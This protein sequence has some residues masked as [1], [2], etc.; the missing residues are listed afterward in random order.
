MTRPATTIELGAYQ[1][2]ERIGEGGSGQ[3]YRARG[4]AGAVAV[5]VLGPA[6]DLDDAARARFDRE[7]AALGQF[8]HP[9]LVKLIDHGIDGELGP[10]LVLPLLAGVNLRS[11]CSGRL[12]PEAALLVIQPV[13][14]AV[15][16]LHAHGYVHRDLKPENAIAAPDGK[17]TVIDL[18]LAWREG[19]T[20]HT[21]TGA[22]VGS[23]GYMAPE[24]IEGRAVDP[25]ADVWGLGVMLYEMIAGKRPFARPRPAEEAAAALLG[26]C[27]KLTAADRR[28]SEELAELVARCFALDPAK[29]PTAQE[30]AA[31][32]D[33]MIDWSDD[34][35]TERAAAVADPIGY[36]ARVAAFRI[37]RME[38]VAQEAIDAGVPFAAL[39]VCDR[40]LAYAPDHAGL[41]AL[42]AAAE[43][44]TARPQAPSHAQPAASG[45]TWWIVAASVVVLAGVGVAAKL[46]ATTSSDPWAAPATTSSAAPSAPAPLI[47]DE[48]DRKMVGNLL[49]VFGR[50]MDRRDGTAT[51]ESDRALT[52]DMLGLFG[53]AMARSGVEIKT[54]PHAR[55]RIPT[56][57]TG[58][59]Q[60]AGTEEPADALA[61][62]HH[63]LE[64][65]P[66]SYEAQ[67]A[68]CIELAA[69]HRDA[70]AIAAC[71]TILAK[72]KNAYA[73]LARGR[74]KAAAGDTAGAKADLAAA[75]K[76]GKQSACAELP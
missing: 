6:S 26:A 56:T 51:P 54:D 72:K 19:M 53:E 7:I 18:G 32:I 52:K 38:R 36:Q 47:P 58:W 5:K 75:C 40:G 39:A 11:L 65:E 74:A 76:L 16:A 61:S 49:S 12:C 73:L 24:Q 44:A 59:L 42:V 27:P 60:R 45:R 46:L 48:G 25:K 37:R 3:I 23:V 22:A 67:L 55:E 15:A 17:I 71:D 70:D 4:P 57:A 62:V 33:A 43:A 64:L 35:A 66:T 68:L 69:N 2:V 34:L 9:N 31:A 41:L 21:D 14:H 28:A 8:E 30:L 13:V 20:R 29:R 10:Y 1:L 63:A 50:A